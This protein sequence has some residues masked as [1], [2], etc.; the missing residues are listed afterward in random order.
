[1]DMKTLIVLLLITTNNAWASDKFITEFSI[2]YS[3]FTKH[4]FGD[5]WT[6]NNGEL[7]EFNETNEL[8][9][10]SITFLEDFS[11][12]FATFNNSYYVRSHAYGLSY[13]VLDT[14]YLDLGVGAGV[15]H[16][17]EDWQTQGLYIN[18][19]FSMYANLIATI[20][21]LSVRNGSLAVGKVEGSHHQLN[22]VDRLSETNL[23]SMQYA[24][25]F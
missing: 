3:M 1:M 16:G 19:G 11:L 24:Y 15:T 25:V 12:D 5:T 20:H 6:D 2:D 9:G 18:S 21:L 10:I 13:R 23:I 14:Q 22:V 4:L 8:V 17:Y 7:H